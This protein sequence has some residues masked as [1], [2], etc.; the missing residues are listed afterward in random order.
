MILINLH[1]CDI[2]CFKIFGHHTITVTHQI[3]P[4]D[5]EFADIT[6]VMEDS[7]RL[8]DRKFRDFCEQVRK[9]LFA[10]ICKSSGIIR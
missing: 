8:S 6:T 2:F 5:I 9:S 7:P 3:Q 1:L 4:L 10:A